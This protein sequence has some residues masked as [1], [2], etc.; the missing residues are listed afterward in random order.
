MINRRA[1]LAQTLP[2]AAQTPQQPNI[3]WVSCEDTG[4][5]IGCYGDPHAITPNID[6]M[7]AEGVRY[8]HAYTV[9]GVCAPS[10]SGIIT[11]MY[12]TTL[13]SHHMRCTAKLPPWVRPFPAYL[14]DAGYFTTNNAKTD[15]NFDV[16]EGVWDRLG[17]DA[18]WKDR[19]AGRPFFSVFNIETTHESR[20]VLRGA[21]YEKAI[22]GVKPEQRQD[23][24]R[25]TTLPPFYPDTPETRRDWANTY[26]L[27]TAM[28]R[29]FGARVQELKD[30]GLWDN[31][32]VFFW[33]DHG[34]GLPR[35]KR[36]LYETSTHVPLLARIPERY[37][38]AGQ[39]K[40]GSTDAQLVS[41]IDLAPTLLNL[42]GAPMPKHFQG[43]AFL[44]PNLTPQREYVFAARD[45]MDER[46][47]MVRAIRDRRYR[48]I[49]N[50]EP[51]K[52]YYQYM[53][54]PE[55]G[56]T[57]QEIRRAGAS[58][59]VASQW[60]GTKP[61]EELY[62]TQT[63]PFEIHNLAQDPRHRMTLQRLRLKLEDWQKET[64]DLGLIPEPELSVI[65]ERR[66]Y[67]M[68]GSSPV[69]ARYW[70]VRRTPSLSRLE[71]GLLDSAPVVRIAAA[72]RLGRVDKLIEG[73][74]N[75]DPSTRLMAAQALD[76]LGEKA[77]PAIRALQIARQDQ[78]N[79]YLVRVANHALNSLLGESTQ[80]P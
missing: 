25:L 34:V 32:I 12:P 54:T 16:P 33:G 18:H 77:R 61:A 30:A 10:R 43:R 55:K 74:A 68:G 64:G 73:L 63:D 62:D 75:R 48:Y 27:I 52:P 49:R 5:Q 15:Y 40:P 23:P 19:P 37:R 67:R 22:G 65:E 56:P 66:G 47:D 59:K 45:R 38:T 6:Q 58:S 72:Q 26:E 1:F 78:E 29:Q 35:S 57:M 46:Y 42:A 41:L 51:E 31:T 14:R 11:G 20:V 28:D 80:V 60:M 17:R 39:G 76:E 36:W 7:A 50:F 2:L 69:T 79:R 71:S 9:A 24:A 13:G 21:A 8:S 3:L 4:T 44:G 70:E 53:T